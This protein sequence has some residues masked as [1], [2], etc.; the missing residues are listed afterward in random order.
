MKAD[1]NTLNAVIRSDFN[2][3]LRKAAITLMPPKSF[4]P[5]WH[6]GA[7]AYHL[8]QCLDGQIKR[9][10]VTIPPR[11]LKSI[12]AS[13][14]F[15]L[16]ALG[17]EL[18]QQIICASYNEDLART[19]ANQR[20]MVLQADWFSKA[21]PHLASNIIAP[22]K[23][24]DLTTSKNGGIFATSVGGTLTGRGGNI[25]I[26]D[27]PMKA[28]DINSVAEM[29]RVASWY[30]ESLISRLNDK[31]TGVI[32][33]IMQRL[34]VDDLVGQILTLDDWVHLNLPAISQENMLVHVNDHQDIEWPAG[35]ALHEERE[36]L[37]ELEKTRKSMGSYH[38]QAQYLQ[39]PL[40]AEGNLVKR[41]WFKRYS[42]KLQATDFE[43]VLHSWDTAIGV[44]GT[45]DYSVCTA[46]GKRE[47]AYYLLDVW[48]ERVDFPE[49]QR[50]VRL[51]AA[52]DNPNKI[53]IEAAPGG[54]SLIQFLRSETTL[55]IVE[56]PPKGDKQARLEAVSAYFEGGRV[57]LPEDA[58]WLAA[59][60]T[61][62]CGFPGAAHDD[63]VDSTSQALLT[64]A[65]E[66]QLPVFRMQPIELFGR[67]GG[68][69]YF[70]RT[71]KP[72]W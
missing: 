24:M 43:F 51:L 50:R 28:S 40:P 36:G 68:D 18:E 13:V 25:I 62:L 39:D 23:T 56:M 38:F 11:S 10:I 53:V 47:N 60:E 22:T 48:R 65:T 46:W 58:D 19:L 61:E 49:L 52:R 2:A 67:R 30:R 16:F 71:G 64:L 66:P 35:V 20:M 27:D 70:A 59:Y 1:N 54:Q 69:R 26:I 7:M 55:P 31:K 72:I 34:H 21:F 4:H 33:V 12:T 63:Q 6:H 57:F 14:A 29:Q 37:A 45:N 42:E 32:I 5:N 8:Q 3:M 17:R 15:P 44:R 9:L 41:S